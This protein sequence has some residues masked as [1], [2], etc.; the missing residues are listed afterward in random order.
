MSIYPPG[1]LDPGTGI[2]MAQGGTQWGPGNFGFLDQLGNGANGVAE[3]LASNDLFGNCQ[4]TSGV[5]TETGNVL[6][7]VRDSSQH[8]V[9]LQAGECFGVQERSVPAIHKC[10]QGRGEDFNRRHLRLAVL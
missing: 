10:R 5:T 4:P 9:R 1:G 7:A 6:N 8:A 3:A 2:V